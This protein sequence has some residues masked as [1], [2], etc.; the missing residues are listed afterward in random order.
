MEHRLICPKFTWRKKMLIIIIIFTIFKIAK[1]KITSFTSYSPP[2]CLTCTGDFESTTTES[3]K[4]ESGR[5]I[6]CLKE[7]T[8]YSINNVTGSGSKIG[9]RHL[10]KTLKIKVIFWSL[11]L[12]FR[13]LLLEIFV[14][15]LLQKQ[16]LNVDH[17]FD[18]GL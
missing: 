1:K 14:S 3:E 9:W 12:R 10:W 11:I 18:T 17:D 7:S 13:S 16:L 4:I 15:Q 8:T 2:L 5:N 6:Q